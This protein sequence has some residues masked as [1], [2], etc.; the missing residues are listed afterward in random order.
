MLL[1][2][3]GRKIGWGF[4]RNQQ[5]KW[6]LNNVKHCRK[7]CTHS[8]SFAENL[9]FFPA[10]L[11]ECFS[12]NSVNAICHFHLFLK[13]S[14]FLHKA[15]SE[16]IVGFSAKDDFVYIFPGSDLYYSALFFS[17]VVFVENWTRTIW[18]NI[19]HEL[20]ETSYKHVKWNQI[21][22]LKK[23]NQNKYFN[24]IHLTSE[25][26]YIAYWNSKN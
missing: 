14:N 21:N 10:I 25:K 11:C 26:R 2:W 8:H 7:K 4:T 20:I 17:C 22:H 12:E 18:K 3:N 13:L 9:C 23:K 15:S 6:M 1:I 19:W 16:K 24:V 5:K